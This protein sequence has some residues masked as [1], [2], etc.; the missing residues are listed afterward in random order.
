MS[1]YSTGGRDADGEMYPASF[2]CDDCGL[3]LS[4]PVTEVLGGGIMPAAED[5]TAQPMLAMIREHDGG[6]CHI[7]TDALATAQRPTAVS[8]PRHLYFGAEDRLLDGPQQLSEK[9]VPYE[10]AR[11]QKLV[12]N[13]ISDAEQLIT[14]LKAIR[15]FDTKGNAHHALP[16]VADALADVVAHTRNLV[17]D[18]ESSLAR[19][20]EFGC[21]PDDGS[22]PDPAAAVEPTPRAPAVADPKPKPG[23]HLASVHVFD[24][25]GSP[26]DQLAAFDRAATAAR[27]AKAGGE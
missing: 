14:A 10:R 13:A 16:Q 24:P 27:L 23:P 3:F 6:G 8:Y 11:R 15:S 26:R 9:Y 18:V 19:F 21:P 12:G 5:P 1:S 7:D 25:A 4:W 22:P 17:E 20:T 2:E